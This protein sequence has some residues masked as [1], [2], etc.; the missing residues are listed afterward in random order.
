MSVRWLRALVS[1]CCGV[2]LLAACGEQD[3]VL[4]PEAEALP[5][6]GFIRVAEKAITRSDA[7]N[8]RVEA[9]DTVELRARVDGFVKKRLFEEG[10]DVEVG[11]LLIVLEK[12]PYQA[13]IGQVRGQIRAAEGTMRLA[14]V[15]LDRRKELRKRGV[16]SQSRLDQAQGT[17]TQALGDLERLRAALAKSELDLGYTD[18]TA[19][20]DGRIGRSVF[21]VGNFVGPASG[22]L[23]VIVSQDPMYVSFPVSARRLLEVRREAAARGQDVRAVDVKLRLPDGSLYDQTGTIDFV[24]VQVDATTDTVTVRAKIAN[25]QHP[26]SRRALVD[27]QLVGVIVEQSQTDAALVIPQAAILVDQAGPH[28]FVVD[29]ENRVE[30]RRIVAGSPQGAEVTL[31][32]GLEVGDRVIVEGLQRV[33]PGDRVAAEPVASAAGQP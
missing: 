1:V 29:A 25:P 17:Y 13:Q 20:I 7:Y 3:A 24:D 11:E 18:I 22:P 14:K 16:D 26:D 4:K 33:R 27:N 31:A 12:E 32:E 19:P 30:Q 9:V 23:A 15:D 2:L 10:A 28:V 8:A 21:S 5:A 6:V